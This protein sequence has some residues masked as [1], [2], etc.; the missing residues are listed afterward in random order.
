MLAS[1]E[2]TKLALPATTRVADM[3]KETEKKL[4]WESTSK[5]KRCVI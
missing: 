2:D 1:M 3:Q 5:L 4:G